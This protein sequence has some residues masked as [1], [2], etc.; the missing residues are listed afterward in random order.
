M[1]SATFNTTDKDVSFITI[2]M[3]ARSIAVHPPPRGGVALVFTAPRS[4]KITVSATLADA[5]PNCGDGIDYRLLH[6]R[7]DTATPIHTGAILNGKSATTPKLEVDLAQGDRIEL[8]VLPKAEYSCDTTVVDLKLTTPTGTLTAREAFLTADNGQLTTDNFH[9]AA[10]SDNARI[11]ALK[12]ELA[13][14]V[15]STHGLQDGGTPGS[16]HAGAH[17]VKVHLRGRYDH[18]GDLVPRGVPQVL[19]REQ[20]KISGGSGRLELAQWIASK[21]NPLTARVIV[22]R[23]WQWHFGEGLVRTPNNFGKLG[24]PPTHPELLDHLATD[25]IKSNWSLKGMHRNIMLSATY[26]QSSFHNSS[27]RIQNSSLPDPDNLLFARANRQRLDSEQLRDTML[28]VTNELD[29]QLNGPA[30]KDLN[31]PRRTLYLMTIRSDRTGY[32]ML[33]DAADPTAIIDKRTDSTVAPQALFLLNHPFTTARAKKLLAQSPSG[34]EAR[35]TWLYD[36]LFSRP[37]TT[38]EVQTALTFITPRGEK[39]WEQYCHA[40]LCSNELS[41]VD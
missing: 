22:N 25:L 39:A 9:F 21:D 24:T 27:F 13:K 40:L 31:A 41:Y 15:P 38:G 29:P 2:K 3:A 19:T 37:P 18:L 35:I 11:A 20:P 28:A 16:P 12:A 26:Q 5:D 33:F 34:N 10:L 1:P 23:L 8:L 17:D 36:R 6:R 14:P 30:T 32:R 4:G 7:G